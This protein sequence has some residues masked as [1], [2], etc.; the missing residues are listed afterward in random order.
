MTE[1][2]RD[3]SHLVFVSSENGQ[4]RRRQRQIEVERWRE[5]EIHRQRDTHSEL[6]KHASTVCGV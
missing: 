3:P 4:K 6:V 2:G 1:V 5:K